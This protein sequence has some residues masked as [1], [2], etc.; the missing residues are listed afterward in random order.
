MASELSK[1]SNTNGREL[2]WCMKGKTL[3]Q[4]AGAGVL[5]VTW[6][7]RTARAQVNLEVALAR[8][9]YLRPRLTFRLSTLRMHRLVAAL[10]ALIESARRCGQVCAG[11]GVVVRTVRGRA[12]SQSGPGAWFAGGDASEFWPRR[13]Y[14]STETNI[15]RA[16]AMHIGREPV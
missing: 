9:R 8:I 14:I 3:A 5:V 16:M 12:C 2:L 10:V 1:R 6:S 4:S 7:R 15:V 11:Y 13:D